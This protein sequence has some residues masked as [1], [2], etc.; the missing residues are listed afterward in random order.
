M[1]W[2]SVLQGK[3]SVILSTPVA[4]SKKLCAIYKQDVYFSHAQYTPL[5]VVRVL[6]SSQLTNYSSI[7]FSLT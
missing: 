3:P 1:L 4:S 2:F 5:E 6:L 7:P